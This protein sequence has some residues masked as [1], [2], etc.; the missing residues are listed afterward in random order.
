[1]NVDGGLQAIEG[2]CNGNAPQAPIASG[3]IA[4]ETTWEMISD[5][6]GDNTE[7]EDGNTAANDIVD[8]G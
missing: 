5:E 1:M 3:V 7:V 2:V 8:A 6:T 4:D